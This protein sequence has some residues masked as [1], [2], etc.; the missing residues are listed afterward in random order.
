LRRYFLAVLLLCISSPVLS[1]ENPLAAMEKF[2]G[3]IREAAPGLPGYTVYRPA[4]FNAEVHGKIPVIVWSNG[5]C[6]SSNDSHLSFLT[7]VAAQGFV[8]IAYGAP[9]VHS[10]PGGIADEFRLKKAID[11]AFSQLDKGLSPYSDKLD[12]GKIATA[13]HSCGGID[14]IWT[15]AHD[16]RVKSIISLNSGCFPNNSTGGKS[17][18][19]AVCRDKFRFLK[20]P[21]LF[22]A[23]GATDVAYKNSA[24][25]F[26]HVS[27][28]PTVFASQE[29][30]G[31]SGFFGSAP[32]DIQLQA[33]RVVVEW[34]DGTLNG[35]AE[36][37]SFLV[38][39]DPELG[40]LN[41][42]TVESSGFQDHATQRSSGRIIPRRFL[43]VRQSSISSSYFSGFCS[44][45][46]IVSP[47][48]VAR[49]YISNADS[50]NGVETVTSF[51]FPCRM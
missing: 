31:H 8:V 20:A 14:A 11:W 24:E 37:L 23:G 9:D 34:L 43:S 28:V 3:V 16:N 47:G 15:G 35:N 5:G 26:K 1:K 39:Q 42:W 10:G 4:D 32:Q 2:H 48:S 29:V 25:S 21:V 38:G 50:A 17:G 18:S 7:Q 40:Q 45:R 51:Q 49:S 36:S 33:V 13:G 19:L 12:S 41:G 30:A 44:A 6:V 22:V 46:S 27:T